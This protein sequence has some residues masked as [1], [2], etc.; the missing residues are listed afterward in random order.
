M[1]IKRFEGKDMREALGLVRE[2]FGPEALVLSTRTLKKNHGYFGGF[3]RSIIEITAAVDRDVR[4]STGAPEP[5]PTPM[6]TAVRTKPDASWNELRLTQALIHPLEAEIQQ[7][8][9]TLE[10][11]S[12]EY[13]ASATRDL[14]EE[15]AALRRVALDLGASRRD[16]ENPS[17]PGEASLE[18]VGLA[19]RHRQILAASGSGQRVDLLARMLDDALSPPRP[20]NDL[21]TLYVGPAGVGKTTTLA[22]VASRT[23]S[24]RKDLAIVST[25]VHRLAAEAPL[26]AWAESKGIPFETATSPTSVAASISR[27]GR[28]PVLVDTAG[29][30][31]NDDERIRALA[32][33]RDALGDRARVCLVLPATRKE[34]DLREDFARFGALEPD[35]L[36]ITR[37]DESR[38]L[39]N[40]A[41]LLLDGGCPPLHWITTGQ[42]VPD[43]LD[44]ADPYDLAIRIL[45]DAA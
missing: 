27:L 44:V 15:V 26:K 19:A 35:A 8:R 23:E 13:D 31:G 16:H 28:R 21:V 7:L 25:D 10:R 14:R 3:S 30:S 4:R 20:E 39:G 2:E 34:S 18:R 38:D 32:G 5:T 40:V 9:D 24:D 6:N 29:C 43:D 45:G 17:S 42:R 36:A 12:L 33:L 1:Q 11:V 22:K 37:V 41:N